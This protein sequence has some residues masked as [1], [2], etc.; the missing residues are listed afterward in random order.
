MSRSG[1]RNNGLHWSTV[2]M[3]LS[4]EM[5]ETL[6]VGWFLQGLSFHLSQKSG[7]VSAFLLKAF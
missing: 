1:K 3:Q 2:G 7:A 5:W 4:L 6:I